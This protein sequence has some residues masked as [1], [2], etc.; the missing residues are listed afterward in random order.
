MTELLWSVYLIE[1]GDGSLYCGIA[2][3]IERRLAEHTSGTGAR[4]TR[5]RGP[6]KL[7]WRSKEPM[8]RSQATRLELK[9][10]A[11]TRQQKESLIRR[12]FI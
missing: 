9:I 7:V 8:T 4:Y 1:C 5:G 11:L 2:V 3:N 12:G 10:K 6:F